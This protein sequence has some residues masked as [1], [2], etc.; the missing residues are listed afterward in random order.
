MASGLTSIDP[1]LGHRGHSL[2]HLFL[3]LSPTGL[4]SGKA[5]I[6][7]LG[8]PSRSGAS[9]F[10]WGLSGNLA[11]NLDDLLF[12]V[13]PRPEFML[14]WQNRVKASKPD[15]RYEALCAAMRAMDAQRKSNGQPSQ[16][17]PVLE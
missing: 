6:L 4:S 1:P 5:I 17:V 14:R 11:M 12:H 10:A 7:P 3:A 16:Y 13:Y 9:L 15:P 8:T 2:R